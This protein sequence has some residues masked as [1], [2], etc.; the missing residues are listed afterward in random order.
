PPLGPAKSSKES[1]TPDSCPALT[2]KPQFP[3]DPN[4][5]RFGRKDCVG[6]FN[7]SARFPEKSSRFVSV[8]LSVT[9]ASSADLAAGDSVW[10]CLHPTF[11]PEWVRVFF[12]GRTASLTVRAWGGF[13]VGAWLPSQRI[14][15][16]YNLATDQ[17]A[18]HIIRAR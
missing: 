6:G 17:G 12:R 18:P 9:A 5:G 4:R 16:E 14:E 11:N 2:R 7:L 3:D 1:R 8:Q 15:L 13:T 10:F